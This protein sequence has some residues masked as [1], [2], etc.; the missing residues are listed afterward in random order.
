MQINIGLSFN[1]SYSQHAG[2]LIASILSS[3]S[4]EDN[5]KFFIVTDYISEENKSKIENLKNI[6]NFDIKYLNVNGDI[7]KS[8]RYNKNL[9]LSAFYRF[10]L[11]SIKEIDKIL[12]LDSDVIVR[13]NIAELFSED[14]DNYYIA[15]VEDIVGKVLIDNYRLSKTTTYIN[16]GVML[17]NLKKLRNFDLISELKKIPEYFIANN[18]GDQDLINYW[19]QD[20]ILPLDL[21]WNLCYPYRS[22]Y[23][24]LNYYHEIAKDPSIFH[25][26]TD[27]KPWIAG[28]NPKFKSE[29]FKYLSK[30][31]W[32]KEFFAQYQIEENIMLFEKINKIMQNLRI[33]D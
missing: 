9:N 12:Y 26:I 18:F 29:Y 14:I 23:D 8:I 20:K 3:A 6:K 10:Y 32:Y 16:S 28:K 21:K 13:H 15:G 4:T 33:A 30:T 19:F 7:F 17:L 25:F 27:A 5:Y 1:D 2:T 31:E 24:N 11:F 22:T